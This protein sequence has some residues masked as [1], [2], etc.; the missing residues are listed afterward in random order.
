MT[1]AYSA[2]VSGT[3]TCSRKSLPPETTNTLMISGSGAQLRKPSMFRR[4]GGRIVT[5]MSA[6]TWR[7][8]AS[9]AIVA[10]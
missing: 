3:P 1:K 5:E 2:S 8:S 9:I 10:W 6:C 7:P 4:V